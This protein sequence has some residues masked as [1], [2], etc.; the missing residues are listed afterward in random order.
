M[1]RALGWLYYYARRTDDAIAQLRMTLAMNPA[2]EET[3]WVLGLS[4]AQGGQLEE[5]E[6]LLRQ[7]ERTV[8]GANHHA[9]AALVDIAVRQGRRA[10]AE[11]AVAALHQV[12]K[13]RYV[14]PVD[15]ARMYLALGDA[16][17]VFEWIERAREERRGWLVYLKVEPNLGPIRSD[18]RY[19]DL[20]RRMRLD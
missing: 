15:F 1:Q 7:A 6:G 11:A 4:L 5:A 18:P 14:S 12:A 17:R 19:A 20:L 13:E 9:Y 2:S 3:Q 10:E 16:D 8:A